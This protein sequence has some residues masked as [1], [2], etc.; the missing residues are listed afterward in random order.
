MKTRTW[1]LLFAA[2]AAVLCVGLAGGIVLAVVTLSRDLLRADV[3][4]VLSAGGRAAPPL[5]CAMFEASRT[6]SCDF[7]AA[8]DDIAAWTQALALQPVPAEAWADLPSLSQ[9]ANGCLAPASVQAQPE[10][11]WV[12]GAPPQ[13]DLPNGGQFIYL[14]LVYHPATG[15]ACAQVEYAY[16]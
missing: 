10:V 1:L 2:G 7:E 15:R 14:M 16:G 12:G 11:Y 5:T 4:E 6:G 13:L 8:D 3:A 9:S